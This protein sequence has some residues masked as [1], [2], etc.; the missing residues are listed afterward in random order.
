[1]RR[2]LIVFVKQPGAGRVKTRLG[3]DIGMTNAAW[4]YRHQTARLIRGLAQ[5]PRWTTRLAIAPDTAIYSS[6]WGQGLDRVSQGTGDLGARMRRALTGAP[7]GPVLLIGSDIPGITAGHIAGAFHDLR[8]KDV[9]LGP[10][11][12]GGYWLIGLANSQMRVPVQALQG[13]RWSTEDAMADTMGSL[14]PLRIGLTA[15]M[16]DVDTVE[17]LRALRRR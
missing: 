17:D 2:T 4:W 10:S 13:V 5:D 3:R 7:P 15:E 14:R 6:I 9:V 8:G 11:M 1:M 12:D 16:Q